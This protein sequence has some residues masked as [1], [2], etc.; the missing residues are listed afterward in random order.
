MRWRFLGRYTIRDLEIR[1][2]GSWGGQK[3]AELTRGSAMQESYLLG[4]EY[5]SSRGSRWLIDV[6]TV[7]ASA[8]ARRELETCP[9][10]SSSV[11]VLGLRRSYR[12][13][14]EA[15]WHRAHVAH[16]R[17]VGRT[18]QVSLGLS[19]Y[20][21]TPSGY[22]ESWR[23]TFLV[24]GMADHQYDPLPTRRLQLAAV[25]LGFGVA[26]GTTRFDLAA[27]QFVFA[28]A[29]QSGTEP[30]TGAGVVHEPSAAAAS[31]SAPSPGWSGVEIRASISRS[32]GS[33]PRR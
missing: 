28:K 19:G 11:G 2:I 27:Q 3:F 17:P 25:S 14:G 29:F 7:R 18:A 32:F 20:D 4:A 12:A 31:S 23:P 33:T 26:A 8:R 6:E 13:R 24:F 9:C 30:T 5:W 16:A 10:T 15:R 21:V 1:G 22:L